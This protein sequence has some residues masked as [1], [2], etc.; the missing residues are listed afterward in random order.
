[1]QFARRREQ[2]FEYVELDNPDAYSI[3]DVLGAIELARGYGLKVI[4]KNPF[5]M[6]RGNALSYVADRNV[7]GVIVERGA[8]I[9]L[10]Y[11]TLRIRVGKPQ[12]PVWFVSF[13]RGLKWARSCAE[14]IRG[15]RLRGMG[16]TYA[17]K[18]QYENSLDVLRPL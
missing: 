3:G 8:G 15:K 1:M 10:D 4:A 13:G 9:P 7:F 2:G 16:V 17:S 11:H 5:L 18:G 6:G 12:L 14:Q